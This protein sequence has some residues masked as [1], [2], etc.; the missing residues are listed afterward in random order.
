MSL[1]DKN[2]RR[3]DDDSLFYFEG[4]SKKVS[5]SKTEHQSI[6]VTLL[7]QRF[8]YIYFSVQNK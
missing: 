7:K 8:Y 1:S 2:E 5:A 3:E 6:T 4:I